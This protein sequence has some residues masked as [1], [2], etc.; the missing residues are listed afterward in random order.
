MQSKLTKVSE[1]IMGLA[2]ADVQQSEDTR[3]IGL[4]HAGV[5]DLDFPLSFQLNNGT[6][7]RVPVRCRMSVSLDKSLKGVNMS[8]FVAILTE[9]A[10]TPI[11]NLNF[12]SLLEKMCL[13]LES[14]NASIGF[15]FTHFV[16]KKAPVTQLSAPMPI[17]CSVEADFDKQSG[18]L[19]SKLTVLIAIGNLCPCSKAISEFGAHNQRAELTAEVILDEH[20]N[21]PISWIDQLVSSLEEASSSPVYPFLKRP[22]EKAVTER[23]Y[24]NPKFVEDVVR[25]AARI[26]HNYSDIKGFAVQAVALESIHA[27]NAWASYQHDFNN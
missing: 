17:R 2:L 26:L 5:R 14:Q 13:R 23:Q 4:Q 16:D 11:S 21:I 12:K 10:E 20:S 18:K 7:V 15:S 19:S 6:I 1:T 22:D 9:I 8:R 25:D 24:E 27:H 3:G